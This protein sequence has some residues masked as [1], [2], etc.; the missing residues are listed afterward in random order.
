MEIQQNETSEF[1]DKQQQLTIF[2]DSLDE[3]TANYLKA[4]E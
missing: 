2:Y 3:D 1:T 4:K